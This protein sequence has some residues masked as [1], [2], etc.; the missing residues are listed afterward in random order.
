MM[1][2]DMT[3]ILTDQI[4]EGQVVWVPMEKVFDTVSINTCQVFDISV[5][6]TFVENNNLIVK[7]SFFIVCLVLRI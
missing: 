3:R 4:T 7:Y 1:E 6:K 5:F 2:G